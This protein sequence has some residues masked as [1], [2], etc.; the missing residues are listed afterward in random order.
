MEK[1]QNWRA[2]ESFLCYIIIAVGI[3]VISLTIGIALLITGIELENL[4]FPTALISLPINEGFI[5]IVAILFA[6]QNNANL[7]QLG[8]RRP[9]FKV[10]ITVSL[11]AFLLL[12]IGGIISLFEEIILGPDP[13]SQYILEAIL[14]KDIFQLILLLVFSFVLVGPAEEIAFRGFIQRGFENSFGQI[15]G[16]IIASILFGLLHGLNSVRSILPVFVVS[17][18]LG[19]IWQKTLNNTVAVAWMHGLYDAVAILITYFVSIQF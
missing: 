9:S 18:F 4:T 2:T 7:S 15:R 13:S 19:Y 16:L 3:F 5:L 14:P 10:L 12:L 6:K 17:L 8:L 11:V 1:E